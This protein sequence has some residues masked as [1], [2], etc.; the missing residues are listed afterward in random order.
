MINKTINNGPLLK[1]AAALAMAL[2]LML[3]AGPGPMAASKSTEE[4]I[5]PKT[6]A[7]RFQPSGPTPPGV[8][9]Y[10][11][12]PSFYT[13]F[14]PRSQEPRR[15]HVHLGRGNQLRV[16]VVL[17]ERMIDTYIQDLNHRYRTYKRLIEAKRM[18]LTQN[19]GWET[20]EKTL[21]EHRVVEL[22]E[23]G[24]EMQADLYRRHNIEM[25]EELNPGRIF[26]IRIDFEKRMAEWSEQLAGLAATDAKH[27]DPIALINDMLPTRMTVTRMT[28]ELSKKFDRVRTLN[29]NYREAPSDKSWRAFYEAASALFDEA[30]RGLYPRTGKFVDVYEF[31]A[32]YP[33]GTLNDTASFGDQE[34]PLYP[35][36]GRRKLMVHQRTRIIDHIPE[37]ACYGYLPWLPYMHVGDRLHN[38]FHSLWFDIDT[39]RNKFIPEAWK[40]NNV[41]SRTGEPYTHLWLLSRGPMSHGCTHVNAGHILELRQ[42]MPSSEG[43]MADVVT[44]RNKSN[45][46]DI[47]DID[48]DGTPEVMGVKYYYSYSLQGKKP[49]RIRAANDRKAF[50]RWLYKSGYR[51]LPDGRLVFDHATATAFRENTAVKGKTYRNIALYEAEYTPERLQFIGSAPIPFV[52]ELRRVNF[53]Y[54]SDPAFIPATARR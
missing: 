46:F 27:A 39:R 47:F 51:Y 37:A 38:A 23:A 35:F 32:I 21:A 18:T 25:L 33:V 14:A 10:R 28:G 13:G 20:F 43:D 30:S 2:A 7:D 15:I 36:P 3:F 4:I 49:N 40:R 17:S 1:L 52:R 5:V 24:P 19:T 8:F 48:G 41:G 29:L 11:L 31:T 12:E 42:A 34:M 53:D 54:P 26:H 6:K 50:Y 45:H 16:T 22:A 44:F 9:F